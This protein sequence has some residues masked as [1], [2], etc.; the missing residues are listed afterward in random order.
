MAAATAAPRNP[1]PIAGRKAAE[2]ASADVVALAAPRADVT[3]AEAEATAEALG[4]A[5]TASQICVATEVSAAKQGGVSKLFYYVSFFFF[6]FSE[7]VL[8]SLLDAKRTVQFVA[9]AV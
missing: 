5:A 6:F 7:N 1:R 8:E 3:M 9:L 4:L 2:S